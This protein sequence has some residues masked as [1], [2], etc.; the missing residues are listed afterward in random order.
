MCRLEAKI[1]KLNKDLAK[2]LAIVRKP[3]ISK[4]A[5]MHAKKK[6]MNI[7]K[8]KKMY[9]EHRDKASHTRMT[10]DHQRYTKESAAETVDFVKT[11]QAS[12]AAMKKWQK[13]T[14]ELDP[15]YVMDVMDD[16][17]EMQSVFDELNQATS[18]YEIPFEVDDAELEAEMDLLGDELLEE[19]EDT[20]VPVYL[21]DIELP[22]A[23]VESGFQQSE[24][25]ESLG[26]RNNPLVQ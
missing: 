26:D 2:E 5:Q 17:Q 22:A 14:K 7:L 13:Q 9:E 11:M 6:A 24:H 19:E 1:E 12:N 25:S 18:L 8:Q 15:D 23:P 20:E 10:V 3:G 16:V 21:Q 4:S